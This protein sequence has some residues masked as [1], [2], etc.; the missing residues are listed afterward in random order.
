MPEHT[1]LHT[2]THMHTHI[3]NHTHTPVQDLAVMHVLQAQ[4][5]LHKPV[6]DGV[7]WQRRASALLQEPIQIT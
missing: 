6:Q 4:A 2:Y 1:H 5:Q 3:P 7:L